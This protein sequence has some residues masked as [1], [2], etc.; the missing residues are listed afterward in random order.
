MKPSENTLE[1]L[2]DINQVSTLGDVRR[3]IGQSLL[4]LARKEISATDVTA[5]AKGVDAISNSLHAEILL[6]K[7]AHE[8]RQAGANLGEIV[9][10]GQ[11]IIGKNK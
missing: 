3:I 6:A 2:S 7:T 8:L 9:Q 5:I 4:A 11:T 10:L 1:S